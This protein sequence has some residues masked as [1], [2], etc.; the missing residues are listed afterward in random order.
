MARFRMWFWSRPLAEELRPRLRQGP[1]GTRRNRHLPGSVRGLP[2]G[3]PVYFDL[4]D[5]TPESRFVPSPR[6]GQTM[7]ALQNVPTL[8]EEISFRNGASGSVLG[9]NEGS[10]QVPW[11]PRGHAPADPWS[12]R[13]SENDPRG[14]GSICRPPPPPSQPPDGCTGILPGCIFRMPGTSAT[15]LVHALATGWPMRESGASRREQEALWYAIIEDRAADVLNILSRIGSPNV[16]LEALDGA[17]PMI[18]RGGLTAASLAAVVGSIQSFRVFV[19]MGF[20]HRQRGFNGCTVAHYACGGG[21][22][23]I[24]REVDNLG[25][26]WHA[27]SKLGTPAEFAARSGRLGA[28]Q[29][30]WTRGCLLVEPVVGWVDDGIPADPR[31]LLWAAEGGHGAVIEFLIREVGIPCCRWESRHSDA[32]YDT[33]LHAACRSG[34]MEAVRVLLD[35]GFSPR[36]VRLCSWTWLFRAW[37]ICSSWWLR[38]CHCRI[39]AMADAALAG[40]LKCVELLS[41]KSHDDP[42]NPSALCLAAANGHIDVMR[43]LLRNWPDAG[44]G[45]VSG[46]GGHRVWVDSMSERGAIDFCGRR[47]E[48]FSGVKR[49]GGGGWALFEQLVPFP[50]DGGFGEDGVLDGEPRQ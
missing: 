11:Q 34:Q 17:T 42:S 26:D 20:D 50:P 44:R 23:P 22:F 16:V 10:A 19:D 12:I 39:T 47:S 2:D 3:D 30:L 18:L 5:A 6:I 48:G 4:E 13:V 21:L 1:L 14:N 7:T 24:I 29:W 8:P 41:E 43:A 35:L 9:W 38:F 27:A 49:R 46:W 15:L 36:S 31:I 40:A 28:L 37:P 45:I 32:P 33:A 25:M